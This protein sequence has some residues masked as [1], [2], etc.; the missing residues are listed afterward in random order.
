MPLQYVALAGLALFL[1]GGTLHARGANILAVSKRLLDDHS[2]FTDKN[3]IGVLRL[4][5]DSRRLELRATAWA[6]VG[7]LLGILGIISALVAGGLAAIR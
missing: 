7:Q 4:L 2:S 1:L 5:S 3:T 6:Q